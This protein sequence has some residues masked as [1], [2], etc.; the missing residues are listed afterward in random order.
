[1]KKAAVFIL[2]GQSNA[3][4]H[5]LPMDEQDKLL[6]PLSH[7][8]GLSRE[9]NQSF[10]ISELT[11]SGY[12]SYGMN[13][14]ETQD[15][16]YSVANLLARQ[17]EA[18]IDAGVTLPPLYIVHIAIGAQGITEGY[19]WNPRYEKKLIPGKL[20]TADISLT[21]LTTHILSLLRESLRKQDLEPEF[22]GIHWRGGENDFYAGSEKYR[23]VLMDNYLDMFDQFYAAL[24]EKPPVVLHR[25]ACVDRPGCQIAL[26]NLHYINHVFDM[27]AQMYDNISVFDVR[28]APQY[29]PDI[30][31]NGIFKEDAVHFTTEVNRWVAEEILRSYLTQSNMP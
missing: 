6:S 17:W 10:D 25:L 19:M 27:L 5:G 16:T 20:G 9:R 15:N 30:R 23:D 1:M 29:V 22:I 7:V 21:L 31:C 2:L 8:F 26:D 13:L 28:R 18:A 24:G 11:W 14:G 3:V 4:G 12:T